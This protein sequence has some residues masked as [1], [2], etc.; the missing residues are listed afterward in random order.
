MALAFQSPHISLD[1]SLNAMVDPSESRNV[2]MQGHS[3]LKPSYTHRPSSH[4]DWSI[5]CIPS[6]HTCKGKLP[7]VVLS[8]EASGM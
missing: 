2:K 6:V 4:T 3:V 7:E 8:A 5:Y 1:F